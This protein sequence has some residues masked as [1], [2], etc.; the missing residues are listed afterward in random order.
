M[1]M[2][3]DEIAKKCWQTGSKA[4]N[5]ENW[6]YAVQMF[7]KSVQLCPGNLAY[8]QSLRGAEHRKYNN[9][10]KGAGMM[11]K[12]K[13]LGLRG[14]IS[15]HKGKGEWDEVD[16]AC[17]EGL[18]LNPW[19]Q[20]LNADAA[21][22][23]MKRG[24]EEV[25]KFLMESAVTADP[26]SVKFNT[27]LANLLEEKGEF[28]NAAAVWQR[29]QRLDPNIF[30]ARSKIMH[31]Q[32]METIDRGGYEGAGSTRDVANL[33]DHEIARRLGRTKKKE[34][35]VDGPGQSEE[36]D[37]LNAIRKEPDNK[38]LYIKMGDYYRRQNRF[39]DAIEYY[40]KADEK[41]GG[42]VNIKEF[43]EDMQLAKLTAEVMDFKNEAMRN[44]K[45]KD[46][47]ERADELVD[48]LLDREI[49]VYA[50]RV[51]RYPADMR[52]KY[53]LARRYRR[54]K[55]WA[56]AIP[57]LQ[58]AS[59]DQ[60]LEVEALVALGKCFI[61]DNRPPMALRQFK[62]AMPNLRH[63]DKPD[64]FKEVYYYV[65]RI[66]EQAGNNSAAEDAYSEIL[67]HDYNYRDVR[68][69]LE[70]LQGGGSSGANAAP[71]QPLE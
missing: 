19:D 48:E 50:A 41:A 29:I 40:T 61:Q 31:L 17:E 46:L 8:R 11:A 69:R 34:E 68:A 24:Y 57:L 25:G 7:L 42:N 56:E 52:M 32:S 51:K 37:I 4:V 62:K 5:A 38:D 60:R 44:P 39:D 22:A 36:A 18:L 12:T 63:E 49:A 47:K 21:E 71:D 23:C 53:E 6:E 2:D 3:Q 43:I 20:Q 1:S 35:E 65:G 58:A 26:E 55:M 15:K 64:V 13:L 59:S 28:K 45:D 10:K 33:P 70:R 54:K 66:E 16:H 67:A 14:K 30:E 27:L 9:N